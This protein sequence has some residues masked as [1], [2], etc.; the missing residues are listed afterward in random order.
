MLSLL[1]CCRT[2]RNEIWARQAWMCQ[3]VVLPG[4]S[5][6]ALYKCA[7][8]VST[9]MSVNLYEDKKN[10]MQRHPKITKKEGKVQGS[11]SDS[12]TIFS[13][14][15][16][17][18]R[19]G[20]NHNTA[21]TDHRELNLGKAK[22]PVP[23]TPLQ[24]KEW[25]MLKEV[26]SGSGCF[27]D[28][29]MAKLISSNSDVDIA[30]SLLTFA[31]REEFGISYKLLLRYLALCVQQSNVAEVYDVYDLMRGKFKSFD[32]GAYTLF[33]KA[34]S[35]TDRWR[36]SIALLETIKKTICP[37]SGNYRDCIKGAVSHGEETLALTLYNEMLERELKPC[38]NTMQALFDGGKVFQNDIYKEELLGILN[39]L[40]HNQIYPGEPL[41]ESIKAW[42]E[43]LPEESWR[44][45]PS[46]ISPSGHCQVCK[47]Q[48][49]SIYLKPEEYDTLK[50]IIL[51][52]VIKGSD[53][54]RK[55]TPEELQEFQRFVKSRAPFD[56]VVDGLNVAHISPKGLPSQNLLD[57]VSSLSSGGKR[58]LV[59]GRKH[60][61]QDSRAWQRRHLQ[62]LQ[63]RADCFFLQNISEDDPF[64]LYA[65]LYSGNH[66]CFLTRDLLRDHKACLP[67]PQIQ[68]LFFKWQRGHQLVIP[69]YSPRSKVV[70]Q[71]ILSYDTIVQ[72][73]DVSWHI[74]YDKTGVKRTTFEVPESWL[75]LR[76]NQ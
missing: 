3:S 70:L 16:S 22:L 20:I 24:V 23:L 21:E 1:S 68:Q 41:M 62:L 12:L 60:M 33:I 27:E 63:Q 55:T 38:D 61:L 31:A 56:M 15:A 74:P 42:F 29:M 37:S 4:R 58:V 67:D 64:L 34:F 45:L 32:T 5:Q 14:G 44:G 40:R 18:L 66:C 50:D 13:A 59:L 6:A 35:Q 28:I 76:R 75:C 54:F 53:T 69:F 49:E 11:L 10:P 51:N 30:K 48:L 8:S 2:F 43:S 26:F 57:V 9:T 46:T 36:E 73:T 71:P 7:Q 19:A 17:K 65:S 47:H 39:S 52:N 25:K 72:N